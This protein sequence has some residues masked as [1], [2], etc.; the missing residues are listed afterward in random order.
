MAVSMTGSKFRAWDHDGKPLAFGKVYTYKA[1]TNAPKE[2]Y[3]SEDGVVA[4]SNPVIL[5]GEGYAD[6]YLDGSYKIVVKDKDDNEINTTDPV[7]AQ[8]GEEWVNS[9]SAS[10]LSPNSFKI[11]GNVTNKYDEGRR[12]RLDAGG[13]EYAYSSILSVVFAGG[14]TTIKVSSSVVLV[15]LIGVSAS[16]VGVSSAQYSGAFEGVSAMIQAVNESITSYPI[17]SRVSTSSYRT[18]S[19]CEAIGASWPDSGGADYVV[20]GSNTGTEDKGMYHDLINGWQLELVVGNLLEVEKFGANLSVGSHDDTN[21]MQSALATGKH[22]HIGVGTLTITDE[23]VLENA[24]QTV[25]G[26]GKLKNDK[27]KLIGYGTRVLIPLGTVMPKSIKTRRLARTL[28]TDPDDSPISVLFNCQAW[29]CSV[30]E[31][32][33]ELECDYSNMSHTNIGAECDIA[34]FNGCWGDANF[35][36]LVIIGYFRSAGIYL[37]VTASQAVPDRHTGQYT[38]KATGSDRVHIHDVE[39]DG[40]WKDVFVAGPILNGQGTYFDNVDGLVGDDRGGSGCSDLLIDGNFYFHGRNHHS[41]RR[42]YD[43][44]MNPDLEDIG[45]MTGSIVIDSRRGSISQGRTR[46]INIKDGR[47]TSFEAARVFTGRAY[48][49]NINWLH[50]EPGSTSYTRYDTNGTEI[51]VSDTVNQTYGPIAC[52]STS[53]NLDGTDHVYAQGIWGTGIVGAWSSSLVDHFYHTRRLVNPQFSTAFDSDVTIGDDLTVMDSIHGKTLTL[54]DADTTWT[55]I[56]G[57]VTAPTFTTQ[58]GKITVIAGMAFLDIVLTYSGLDTADSSSIG[59]F[60]FPDNK[61]A[62]S[63]FS[64]SLDVLGSTALANPNSVYFGDNGSSTQLSLFNAAGAALKYNS[65]EILESGTIKLS[66]HYRV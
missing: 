27:K 6:I 32:S 44:L 41:S 66:V 2:T 59:I 37:D 53:G 28:I 16:I 9:V 19:E 46:R 40:S 43:P 63:S 7:T 65:G 55:P 8:G 54:D 10:Y 47:I 21:A 62:N 29:G 50:T 3:Q 31:L 15:G 48:E 38:S 33:I 13:T 23:L 35:S 5:N 61:D 45:A 52:Q 64:V 51:S 30:T 49:L 22:V 58:V 36:K 57:F 42:G 34:I 39:I 18:K 20:V 26:A 14:E 12:V 56:L 17:K 11:T 1:R 24:A 60:G 25:H 4:N